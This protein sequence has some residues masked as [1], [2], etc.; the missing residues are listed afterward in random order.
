MTA[1]AM[2]IAMALEGALGWP[3]RLQARIGHPV[4]WIGAVIAAL[5]E[6]WN[7]PGETEGRRVTLGAATVVVV[8]GA[9]VLPALLVQAILPGG[10]VGTVLTGILAA[11]LVAGRSLYDHVAAVARALAAN[12]MAGARGAV[13]MIVGRDPAKL[14]RAGIA[15]AALESLAENASDGVVAP[16][17][18]GVVFGLPGIAGYKAINTLDSMIGHRNDRYRQFGRVAARL[19]D[20]ANLIP[21]RLTGVLFCAVARRPRAAL[22]TMRRDARAHRSPNA[23]WPESAMAGGLGVRLSGPRVYGDRISEEP[24]LNAGAPDPDAAAMRAG[25]WLYLR[26]LGA[27]ALMLAVLASTI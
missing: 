21:A 23:G 3:D 20:L 1:A 4:V 9:A 10:W 7:R 26:G 15:R 22:A 13:A 6:R 2:L 27:L 17:F 25:L 19:D 16:V 12:D 5:E 18:W 11:P 14:N 24:W 8:V